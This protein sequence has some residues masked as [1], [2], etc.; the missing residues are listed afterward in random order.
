[1]SEP[2]P[3]FRPQMKTPNASRPRVLIGRAILW[4]IRAVPRPERPVEVWDRYRAR[5]PSRS[6]TIDDRKD[7]PC[8]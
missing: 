3:V 2:I 7:A 4:F 6:S 5:L 1:M 8:H